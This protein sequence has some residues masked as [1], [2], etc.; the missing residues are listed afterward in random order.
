[1]FNKVYNDLKAEYLSVLD[2]I[3]RHD[4]ELYKSIY[5]VLGAG[6]KSPYLCDSFCLRLRDL[7]K[8]LDRS[9]FTNAYIRLRKEI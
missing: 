6:V 7:S 4:A 1:M 9:A 3:N 2:Y 8:G 5:S